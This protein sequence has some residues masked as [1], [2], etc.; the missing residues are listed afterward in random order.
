MKVNSTIAW[1]LCLLLLS[2][3]S[4][5]A[6]QQDPASIQTNEQGCTR[7]RSIGPQDPYKDPA[8]LKQACLGP[9]LLEIPQNY[10]YNN[11]GTEHDGSYAL[12]L[13]YPLLEPFKPGE[14][15]NWDFDV[16]ARTVTFDFSY[17]DRIDIREAMR[18]RYIPMEYKKDEPQEGLEGRI[19]GD[20]V[21]GL[22]PYYLNMELVRAYFRGR[23]FK[24]DA[25]IMSPDRHHDWFLSKNDS[26]EVVTVIKCTPQE[27]TW[28]GVEYRDGK[29]VRSKGPGFAYCSHTLMIAELDTLIEMRYLREGMQHWKRMEQR[30]REL[31]AQFKVESTG[32]AKATSATGQSPAL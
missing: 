11:I 5:S 16:N 29:V 26:G 10:F 1:T 28:S 4:A 20:K 17:I 27:I 30:A 21:Y 7:I 14:R 25:R 18:R 9:Y 15:V 12:T 24:E 2:G 19:K 22:D 23:G 32:N 31:I 3:A 13:E 8:P 6:E